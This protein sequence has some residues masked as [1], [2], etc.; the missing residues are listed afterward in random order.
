MDS[1]ESGALPYVRSATYS[2]IIE[3]GASP[4]DA[5]MSDQNKPNNRKTA[6][7]LLSVALMFF[8]GVIVKRLWFS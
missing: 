5:R 2:E 1:S 6:L 7:I 4:L 8:F 3:G